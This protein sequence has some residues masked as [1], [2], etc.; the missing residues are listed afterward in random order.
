MKGALKPLSVHNVMCKYADDINLLVP[1]HTNIDLK[2]EFN[3]VRQWA[4]VNKMILISLKQKR[5]FSDGLVQSVIT[6]HHPLIILN[7]LIKSDVLV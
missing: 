4:Q 2:A 3:N 1:E 6:S 5:L 7:R